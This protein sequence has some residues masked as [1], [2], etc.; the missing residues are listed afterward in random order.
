MAKKESKS[1]F[2]ALREVEAASQEL[3]DYL[4]EIRDK[5]QAALNKLV[6]AQTAHLRSFNDAMQKQ[7][8]EKK[9]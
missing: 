3:F 5:A 8:D 9:E 2:D 6:A 1:P 7:A 4:V